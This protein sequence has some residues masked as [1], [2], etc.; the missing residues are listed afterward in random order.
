MIP[1]GPTTAGGPG[2]WVIVSG[3]GAYAN[4][5]G[6]GDLTM[7]I[8]SVTLAAVESMEGFVFFAP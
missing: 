7:D 3:T 2:Q 1:T 4:L 8:D 5:H 6:A